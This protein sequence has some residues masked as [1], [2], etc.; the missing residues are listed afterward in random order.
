M[1]VF[2]V[3]IIF[4][5]LIS[6]LF[7]VQGCINTSIIDTR[8]SESKLEIELKREKKKNETL[9]KIIEYERQKTEKHY[10]DVRKLVIKELKRSRTFPVKIGFYTEIPSMCE[11]DYDRIYYRYNKDRLDKIII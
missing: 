7:Y 8:V 6:Y 1:V 10:E 11:F 2:A 5:F 4:I 9:I 3:I